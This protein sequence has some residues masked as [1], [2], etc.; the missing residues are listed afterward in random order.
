L[1]RFEELLGMRD[2]EGS[3][4]TRILSQLAKESAAKVYPASNNPLLRQGTI[5]IAAEEGYR[6]SAIDQR[7]KDP[8]RRRHP[9]A[10]EHQGQPVVRV[11]DSL[12][13]QLFQ[14]AERS[15]TDE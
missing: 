14:L 10:R 5:G 8:G 2:P 6:L 7:L 12:A 3:H 13:C 9:Q 11:R 4:S 1:K 15:L